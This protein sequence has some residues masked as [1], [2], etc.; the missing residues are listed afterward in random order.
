MIL[1]LSI[2]MLMMLFL[3]IRI[4]WVGFFMLYVVVSIILNVILSMFSFVD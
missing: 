4:G 2:L 1:S 3:A